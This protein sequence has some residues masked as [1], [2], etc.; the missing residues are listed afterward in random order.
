[1]ADRTPKVYVIYTYNGESISYDFI[2]VLSAQK[3]IKKW[4]LVSY[5]VI[6]GYSVNIDS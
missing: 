5:V 2:D 3:F 1:M 6:Y 4:H